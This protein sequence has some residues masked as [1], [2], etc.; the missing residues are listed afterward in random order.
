MQRLFKKSL[1]DETPL[2]QTVGP[3]K[4]YDTKLYSLNTQSIL[5]L[6]DRTKVEKTRTLNGLL[7]NTGDENSIKDWIKTQPQDV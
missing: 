5:S 4:I 3:F 6:Q 2:F 7:K 1:M